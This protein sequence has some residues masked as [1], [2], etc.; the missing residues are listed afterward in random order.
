MPGREGR[1][2]VGAGGRCARGLGWARLLLGLWGR[3]LCCR[4]F[5]GRRACLLSPRLPSGLPPSR[6]PDAVRRQPGAD[7]K[8][9]QQLLQASRSGR[10]HGV[11]GHRQCC[12]PA[13]VREGA[14]AGD[15]VGLRPPV[16]W[17]GVFRLR[18]R[19]WSRNDPHSGLFHSGEGGRKEG[20]GGGGGIWKEEGAGCRQSSVV[21]ESRAFSPC[22]DRTREK[23]RL[24][25]ERAFRAGHASS[26]LGAEA[27]PPSRTLPSAAAPRALHLKPAVHTPPRVS[28]A[29]RFQALVG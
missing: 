25:W 5:S 6:H 22:Q 27:G 15:P 2:R 23:G 12:R 28:L 8:H 26:A 13:R 19:A 4:W 10:A 18:G 16:P 3:F 9:L 14:Q 24:I 7:S 11:T 1:P 20:P 29:G 21:H 17:G